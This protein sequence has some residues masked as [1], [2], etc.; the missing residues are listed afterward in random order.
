MTVTFGTLLESPLGEISFYAGDNGLKRLAFM[1]LQA[2]KE[3]ENI[4]DL[5]PSLQGMETIGILL[6]EL[7]EYLFGIRKDFSVKI[8][9]SVMGGFQREVLAFTANIPYGQVLT[10]GDVAK[11]VGKPGASRAV[12]GALGSNPL[13]IVIPCHR[14][15]GADGGLRGYRGGI[16]TKAFL[17]ALEGHNVENDKVAV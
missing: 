14:V 13:P 9:W 1:D 6:S 16:K 12:G 17:L 7:N 2:L 8:D 3:K 11:E 15:I 10:Y 5:L 4:N